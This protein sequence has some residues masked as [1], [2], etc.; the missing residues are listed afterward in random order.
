MARSSDSTVSQG[1][2]APD[3]GIR[4][5][6]VVFLVGMLSL[7]GVAGC[8]PRDSASQRSNDETRHKEPA[9]R[10][11]DGKDSSTAESRAG[12]ARQSSPKNE[13]APTRLPPATGS[14]AIPSPNAICG[15]AIAFAGWL[16]GKGEE[17]PRLL[18]FD[19][20]DNA[21]EHGQHSH[22]WEADPGDSPIQFGERRPVV[23]L[24]PAE[25]FTVVG[26]V[27]L[28]PQA[29]AAA[30][31]PVEQPVANMPDLSQALHDKWDGLCGPTSAADLLYAIASRR[32][33]VLAGFER[34]PSA[35]ANRDAARLIAGEDGKLNP[36][37]LAT[38]MKLADDG[39]GVT[40]EGIRS[41]LETWLAN[42]DAES[43]SVTLQWLDDLKK[44]PEE[45]A[46]FFRNLANSSRKGGGAVLCL[47]PGTEFSDRS[48]DEA[49]AEQASQSEGPN[50]PNN[51][52]GSAGERKP[53]AAAGQREANQE[54]TAGTPQGNKS[55]D[56][57]TRSSATPRADS[58][59]DSGTA[60]SRATQP[61]GEA[62]DGAPS[63]SGKAKGFD[64]K[65]STPQAAA[66]ALDRGR[67]SLER[68][69]RALKDGSHGD[70][71]DAVAIA[72]STLRPH[73]ASNKECRAA[74][75]EAADL[76][77]QIEAG[78]PRQGPVSTKPTRFQ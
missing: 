32:P 76:A 72:I 36:D 21:I 58:G 27:V 8:Q 15:H 54:G 48:T 55:G 11:S 43:W 20:G 30:E 50:G 46:K 13:P 65:K 37:S 23:V 53:N 52:Q 9:A 35:Q 4:F 17:S 33:A 71:M 62:E 3:V 31:E 56:E 19:P 18:F 42:Q 1:D 70:A 28:S 39:T 44:T 61:A 74:L 5:L 63:P 69:T 16:P 6:P 60:D 57:A 41:G 64:G 24:S 7:I 25:A 45:Q 78:M 66:A 14:K 75:K 67:R 47:W 73:A 2:I 51:A 22:R 10:R 49:A 12:N 34:G 38:H 68:A 59:S 26:A 77:A 29:V 40:N